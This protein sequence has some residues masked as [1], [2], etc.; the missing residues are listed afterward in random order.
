VFVT[1]EFQFSKAF[2]KAL[3]GHKALG[4]ANIPHHYIVKNRK[5]TFCKI[6][7]SAVGFSGFLK[8]W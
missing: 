3:A 1:L 6:R 4:Y 8:P 5:T 7:F 2:R